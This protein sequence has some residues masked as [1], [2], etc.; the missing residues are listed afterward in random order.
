MLRHFITID[1]RPAGPAPEWVRDQWI[2]LSLP[3]VPGHEPRSHCMKVIPRFI[4]QRSFWYELKWSFGIRPKTE[5]WDGFLVHAEEAVAVLEKAN[6]T[7]AVGWW[8]TCVRITPS[9]RWVFDA[10]CCHLVPWDD[11]FPSERLSGPLSEDKNRTTS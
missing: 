5:E 3:L 7:K 4:D 11:S 2:G 6:R 1:S 8:R 10:E 9:T